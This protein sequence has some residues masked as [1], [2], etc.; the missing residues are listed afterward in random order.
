MSTILAAMLCMGF[1]SIIGG[2]TG[3]GTALIAAPLM[4]LVGI[5]VTEIV[6]VNLIVGLATRLAAAIQLRKDMDWRR[7]AIL[8]GASAP[9]AWLGAV[10]VSMLPLAYLKPGVGALTV[11]CALAL[12]LPV[13]KAPAPPSKVAV[14]LAGF[15]GGY[16]ST[17]TS[18]NGPPAVLVLGRAQLPPMTFIADLAGYF[19]ITNA[20]S[21]ALLW[22]YSD[23]APGAIWP[24]IAGCMAMGLLGNRI[25]IMIARRLPVGAFRSA[26]IALVLLAGVLTI[27]TA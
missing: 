9:G 23:L 21:L 27:V 12:A 6:V 25:G 18:L 10:T 3:F 11:L 4:L 17:T 1:A 20:V 19:V 7:V 8:G 5:E 15:T 13:R 24:M 26:V 2:A 16:L 14:G 22:I